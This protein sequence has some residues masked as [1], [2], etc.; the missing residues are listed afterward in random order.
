MIV[1]E[2]LEQIRTLGLM[3]NEMHISSEV[4][5]RISTF[6][7]TVSKLI[8]HG[9]VL[10]DDLTEYLHH[11]L[12]TSD[13]AFELTDIAKDS[14]LDEAAAK[15]ANSF[16]E[17]IEVVLSSFGVPQRDTLLKAVYNWKREVEGYF[18]VEC[19]MD[20][21]QHIAEFNQFLF[22]FLA[23]LT[24]LLLV[25][26][27]YSG[28]TLF[29]APNQRDYLW[30]AVAR[31]EKISLANMPADVSP[32]EYVLGEYISNQVH[33]YIFFYTLSDFNR[34]WKLA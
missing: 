10:P 34:F 9:A 8:V 7:P 16:S 11:C 1:N 2:I 21:S 30:T 5:I 17:A 4:V 24:P 27:A 23:A 19:G 28:M 22:R 6:P 25:L 14:T 15:A 18:K 12:S 29:L 32:K 26:V 20:A 3:I 33:N 13:T 31:R